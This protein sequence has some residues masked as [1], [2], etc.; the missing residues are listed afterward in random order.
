MNRHTLASPYHHYQC[1]FVFLSSCVIFYFICFD[2]VG[3]FLVWNVCFLFEIQMHMYRTQDDDYRANLVMTD[4]SVTNGNQP[5]KSND[6]NELV[7]ANQPMN[8]RRSNRT[9]K[10]FNQ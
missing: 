3:L 8:K 7:T 6:N 10:R 4:F 5:L 9:N 2:L 1:R